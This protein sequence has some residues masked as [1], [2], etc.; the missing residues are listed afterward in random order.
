M[1]ICP[2]SE[3]LSEEERAALQE[4]KR[5]EKA[6]ANGNEIEN[7]ITKLL[8]LG[9][10]ESGKSTVLKQMQQLYGFFSPVEI[11]TFA[12]VLRRNVV[13][14]LQCLLR[15]R[16]MMAEDEEQEFQF[17]H[18]E[19]Q[20]LAGFVENLNLFGMFWDDKIVSAVNHFWLQEPVIRKVYE[21]RSELQLL[22]STEYLF[23]HIDKIGDPDFQPGTE[24]I[25][26]A[27]LRTSGIVEKMFM[28][29][30]VKFTFIDVGG[31]RNER[32]K[33]IHCFDHVT[34]IIFVA[35]VSE[36]DQV[37][38]EDEK[39]NRMLESIEV[40]DNICNH[41]SF[42]KTSTILFLNKVDIFAEKIKRTRLANYFPEFTGPNDF[43][44]ATDF[45]KDKFLS[46]NRQDKL[47]F[48]HFTTATD[49]ENVERVFDACRIAILKINMNQY[50][51]E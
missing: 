49:T 33:W 14:S 5:I 19:S 26:R 6:L 48:P 1:G 4:S 10:G 45:I 9:T 15:G 28:I 32:R 37:L 18:E 8:L 21:R 23:T 42:R 43:D 2:S 38:F 50:G 3:P 34:A 25:L 46:V 39:R 16:E 30:D 7:R 11:S 24:D 35:A 12:H 22:D 41:H 29:H 17:E 27:R 44:H 51:Y 20:K 13:D 31:Q 47:I 36:F 40:F